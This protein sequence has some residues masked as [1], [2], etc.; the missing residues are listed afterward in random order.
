MSTIEEIL[1]AI[2]TKEVKDGTRIDWGPDGNRDRAMY[3]AALLGHRFDPKCQ[4]CD[5]DLYFVLKSAQ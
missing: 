2:R 1:S 5:S 4:S 3:Q